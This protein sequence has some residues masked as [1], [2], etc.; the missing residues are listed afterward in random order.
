LTLFWH[1]KDVEAN[2]KRAYAVCKADDSPNKDYDGILPRGHNRDSYLEWL[3]DQMNGEF[4]K[5]V[6]EDNIDEDIVPDLG[7]ENN[8]DEENVY[9]VTLDAEKK[10]EYN[11]AYFKGYS[12]F[13]L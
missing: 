1:T 10:V 11:D 13:V 3:R 5:V 6:I 9:S 8:D 7:A 12:A 2:F 4:G